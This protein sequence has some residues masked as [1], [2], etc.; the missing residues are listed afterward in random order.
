[1]LVAFLTCLNCYAQQT[2]LKPVSDTWALTDVNIV[3]KPGVP[4]VFGHILV[5]NGMI[6]AMGP[7]I[8]IPGNA[9]IVEGDSM[10][11]YAGFISGLSFAG[12][13][14][15]E[16]EDRSQR[17]ED[18]GN[19]GNARAGIQ[20][21]NLASD[22]LDPEH[23]DI[24][25]FRKAGFTMAQV[26]PEGRM[27]PG[28]GAI[29][30]LHGASADEMILK[31]ESSM[32]AQWRGAGGVY[33][34][35][36]LGVTATWKDMYRNAAYQEAYQKA[37][38]ENPA[39]K[40]RPKNSEETAALFP[41]VTGELPVM[42]RAEDLLAVHR[43]MALA[44]D[45]GFRLMLGE[46]AQ[47]WSLAQQ[48][49]SQEEVSIFL[50]LSL[51]ELEE[52]TAD[53]DTIS[54]PLEKE[55]A[56][57]SQRKYDAA[58]AHIT[59]A[60]TMQEAG[61]LFGFSTIEV[62]SKEVL[63]NLQIMMEHGLSADAALAA[64]TTSPATLLGVEGVAG[65]VTPGKLANLVVMTGP[66]GEES[67]KIKMTTVEGELFEFEVK[68]KKASSGDAEPVDIAGSW[69]Y[70]VETPQGSNSG[71]ITFEGE[72]G[73][74]TGSIEN[75]RMGQQVDLETVEVDGNLVSFSYTVEGGGRSFNIS[76]EVEVEGEEF[77]GD[78]SIGEFGTYDIEGTKQPEE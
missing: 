36:L 55:I 67:S 38:E 10:Y 26:V 77:E 23:K 13:P 7:E 8:N 53:P 18:P 2:I 16:Q 29:I 21:Q 59:Q 62:K 60:A 42:F 17:V 4:P 6:S 76:V 61:V 31:D 32:F 51:P 15:P 14:E 50:T 19:P 45:L 65:T 12:I 64:L 47:C 5:E 63:P 54:D 66:F 22:I 75:E 58:M 46:V 73:D 24:S 39:G 52:T 37:Y 72:E 3:E 69:R 74:Y 9:R 27:M 40:A 33:P 1:M 71:I 28:Q 57:L 11:V 30:L 41:V 44:E 78:I 35:N 34:S 49:A 20:P 56:A 70:T 25:A 48:F 68:K 43:A